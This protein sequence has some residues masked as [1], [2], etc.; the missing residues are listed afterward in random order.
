MPSINYLR[1]NNAPFGR[2]DT[3]FLFLTKYLGWALKVSLFISGAPRKIYQSP[4]TALYK[5]RGVNR[6][7]IILLLTSRVE[8]E[9]LLG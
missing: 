9:S 6:F 7:L 1:S 3:R 4:L 8:M 2:R 5:Y